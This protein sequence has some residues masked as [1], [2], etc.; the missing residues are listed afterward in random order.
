MTGMP[1]MTEL[2]SSTAAELTVSLAPTTSTTSASSI[3]CAC[4]WLIIYILHTLFD[5]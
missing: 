5:C 4:V 1:A 2:G 3:S